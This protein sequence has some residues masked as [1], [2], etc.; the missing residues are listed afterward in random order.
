M[1]GMSA[2]LNVSTR[3]G[4]NETMYRTNM[5]R[6]MHNRPTLIANMDIDKIEKENSL[7]RHRV[8][9]SLFA[10]VTNESPRSFFDK[11]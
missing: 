4:T 1:K 7:K 6:L 3:D 5:D 10:T 8:S 11:A 2:Q 9:T